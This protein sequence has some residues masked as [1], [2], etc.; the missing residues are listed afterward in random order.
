MYWLSPLHYAL[1]GLVVTQFHEDNTAVT[2]AD[3]TVSTAEAYISGD[4]KEW[5]YSHVGNDVLALCLFCGVSW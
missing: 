3:G 1:E 2:L 5:K 4:F